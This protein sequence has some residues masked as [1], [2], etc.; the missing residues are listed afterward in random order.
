MDS[1][2]TYDLLCIGN[3]T[4]DTI[5]TP[6]GTRYVDG[7]GMNYAARAA[8]RLGVK[9]AV[10]TRLAKEDDR[11]VEKFT[12]AGINC[13]PTYTPQ[14]TLMCLEYPTNDPDIRNLSVTTTAGPITV[15][16]VEN[17]EM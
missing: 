13:Y 14:S 16:E 7:G 1:V 9:V 4:K 12:Q 17:L 2:I 15:S 11:V 8:A 3:Y 5:I 10:V 6:S